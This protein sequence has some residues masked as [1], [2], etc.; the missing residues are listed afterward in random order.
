[1]NLFQDGFRLVGHGGHDGPARP[2]VSELVTH[3]E[4]ERIDHGVMCIGDDALVALI[5]SKKIPFTVCPISNVKI[6]PFTSIVDH[7]IGAMYDYGLV[8]TINSDDPAYLSS[9]ISDNFFQVA[10]IFK[11]NTGDVIQIVRN[12]IEASFGDKEQKFKLHNFLQ[13]WISSIEI[14]SRM[15]VI[16]NK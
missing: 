16:E 2:Y 13:K 3:L 9:Y 4:V 15:G 8:I 10:S 14:D 12:S 6:G 7:P 11:W 5:K 1:M